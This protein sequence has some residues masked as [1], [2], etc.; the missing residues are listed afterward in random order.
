MSMTPKERILSVLNGE[1]PDRIPVC[2]HAQMLTQYPGGWYRRLKERG[3]GLIRPA[4][5]YRPVWVLTASR[6]NPHLPDVKYTRTDYA[7]KGVWKCRLIYDTPAGSITGVWMANPA[8]HLTTIETPEEY[9]IKQPSD[10]RVVNYII[11]GIVDGLA[12]SYRSFTRA[13]EEIGDDGIAI[14]FLGYTAW[15]RAWIELAGPERAVIDF[16]MKLD[17]VQEFIDLHKRWHTRLA[18]FAADSPAKFVDIG[19]N[20]SDMTSPN[21]YREF[22]K[23]I[24]EIYSKNFEGTGKVLGVHMDGRLGSIKKD[25]GETPINVVES[26]SVPPTGDISLTEVKNIWPDK[27]I[28]MNTASHMAWA[29][30]AEVREFYEFLAD[31]WGSK[32]GLIL[33]LVEQLPPDNQSQNRRYHK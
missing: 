14:I 22:C 8:A 3:L 18:E 19:E 20:I 6:P 7:E 11:K 10:W 21:Y 26:F 25:I 30:P 16:H 32:K 29:E 12:P 1:E 31:E 27:K 9:F 33:E 28:F 15:Q 24:Y 17:G 23:P 4:G 13:E 5:F 2:V